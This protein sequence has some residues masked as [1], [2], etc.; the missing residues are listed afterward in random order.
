MILHVCRPEEAV[1]GLLGETKAAGID[2]QQRVMVTGLFAA[3]EH[4]GVK[5]ETD[6]VVDTIVYGGHTTLADMLWGGVPAMTQSLDHMATRIGGALLR[7]LQL[8][9]GD[10]HS[11]KQFED[12]MWQLSD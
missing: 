3:D 2:P 1:A 7:D 8:G 4:V 10:V 5:A 9:Y 12:L 6:L 11:R